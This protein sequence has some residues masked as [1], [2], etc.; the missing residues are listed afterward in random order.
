MI[1]IFGIQ[2]GKPF[3]ATYKLEEQRHKLIS[4]Y[5]RYTS[6]EQS[7]TYQRFIEL[8]EIVNSGTFEKK[9]AEYK[10]FKY[11]D[12]STYLT[13]KRFDKIKSSKIVKTYQESVRK[14]LNIDKLVEI[15]NSNELSRFVE[16][17]AKISSPEF[18]LKSQQPGF[19]TTSDYKLVEEFQFLQQNADI[20]L[21]KKNGE[22]PEF[23]EMV[24][25]MNNR[26]VKDFIALEMEVSSED[27]KIRD[28]EYADKDRFKKSA[29]N[30]LLIE[31]NDLKKNADVIW[32]LKT[33]QKN[34][35]SKLNEWKIIFEDDF[36][37]A[38]LDKSKWITSYFWGQALMNDSYV[39][40]DD[41]QFF[42][43]QNISLR[44]G[45]IT[46][47]TV[48]EKSRGKVW[49]SEK[50]FYQTDLNFTSGIINTGHA[51]RLN[52]GKIEAKV[53]FSQIEGLTHAFWLAGEKATPHINIFKTSGKKGKEVEIGKITSTQGKLNN[54]SKLLPYLML[55]NEFYIYSIEWSKDKIVWK[56][57]DIVV[58]EQSDN[59]PAEA[60][61]INFSSHLKKEID[62]TKLPATM[63]IDWVR[64][65][66]KA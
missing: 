13:K 14:G 28:A 45:L 50:G 65:Y 3:P 37:S 47:S 38:K 24:A 44:D 11:K 27:F 12:S 25:L 22:T 10:S 55:G 18:T 17:E 64:C 9:L 41:K 33:A 43:E 34:Q 52:Y 21:F 61:Y 51:F 42:K 62:S 58:A 1:T 5:Q 2:F 30:R 40:S 48:S 19:E 49:D 46:L 29:E 23:K 4:D 39:T 16:L 36:D 26:E 8:Q 7:A 35:F 53:K 32:Y 63:Q 60:M 56:I 57:N 31:F 59:I 54:N 6:V 15:S 20:I 66:S